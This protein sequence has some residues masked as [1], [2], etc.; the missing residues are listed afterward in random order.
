MVRVNV[1]EAKIPLL[2]GRSFH[3]NYD[4]AVFHRKKEVWMDVDGI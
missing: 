4:V 3:E 1:L 2:L